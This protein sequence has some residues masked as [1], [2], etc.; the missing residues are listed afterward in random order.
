MPTVPRRDDW[1]TQRFSSPQPCHRFHSTTSTLRAAAMSLRA[2][3]IRF[4]TRRAGIASASSSAA[5]RSFDSITSTSSCPLGRSPPAAISS[6][7]RPRRNRRSAN[8]SAP[9]SADD[10]SIAAVSSSRLPGTAAQRSTA[11]SGRTAGCWASGSSSPGTAT[12]TPAASSARCSTG[13]ALVADRAITA[14]SDQGTSSMRCARRSWS[15]TQLASC[16]ADAS[17][18]TCTVPSPPAPSTSRAGEC[19][20]SRAASPCTAARTSGVI[21]WPWLSTTV[22]RS[23]GSASASSAGSAPRKEKIAWSGSP[24]SRNSSAVEPIRS[25]SAYCCGS[26]CWASSTNRCRTRRRSA[27]SSSGSSSNASSALSTSSAASS[28]G[29]I[30]G[31]ESPPISSSTSSYCRPN[32]PAATHSSR[33]C[34]RPSSTRSSGPSPRSVARSSKSLSSAVNPGSPIAG[35]N[36][37]GQFHAPSSTSPASSSSVSYT[38]L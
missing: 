38:H 18:R 33:P 7:R 11:S 15:A 30:D 19:P 12:G 16:A 9:P 37:S 3:L 23:C 22:A 36:R 34:W 10:S 5:S 29:A 26:R 8:G 24:A 13:S 2:P 17:S 6:L 32:S 21:R 1:F 14:I 27:S 28:A 31:E 35:R 20:G 25:S 4:A